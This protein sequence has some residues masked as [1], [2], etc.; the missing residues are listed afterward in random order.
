[1]GLRFGNYTLLR[2][3]K[4]ILNIAIKYDLQ[5]ATQGSLTYIVVAS[6]VFNVHR[7]W[8]SLFTRHQIYFPHFELTLLCTRTSDKDKRVPYFSKDFTAGRK[9][10]SDHMSIL[11]IPNVRFM[12]YF[13][14]INNIISEVLIRH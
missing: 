4:G 7:V 9:T 3:Y 13:I 10:F 12:D 6:M 11:Q 2:S 14:P 8:N 5:Q 1:M